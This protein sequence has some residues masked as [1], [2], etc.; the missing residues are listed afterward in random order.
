VN[1]RNPSGRGHTLLVCAAAGLTA[2]LVAGCAQQPSQEREA[3]AGRL[4]EGLEFQPP[5]PGSYELPVIQAAADGAVIDVDGETRRLF[6]YLG[7]KHV[8]LSL[9]YTRCTDGR[10]CPLARGVFDVMARELG[11]EPGLADGVRLITLSFDPE[12]DTP[13]V[14]RRYAAQ[15]HVETRWDERP[16]VFLT[17]PSRTELQPIL[18]G[19]GQYVVP[20]IDESGNPTGDLAHVLKIFLIDRQHRVRNIYSSS[21]VHPAVAINDLKTLLMENAGSN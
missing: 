11:T 15:D 2:V 18:D 19:Y 17:T 13:D 6:D 7:D 14:M 21:Y 12:R 3:E 4:S 10:G 8:F 1:G 20:E 5:P 16:W 9:V